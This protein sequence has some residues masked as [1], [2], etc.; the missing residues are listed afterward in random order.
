MYCP[1]CGN[2]LPDEAAFC[3]ACGK[4]VNREVS[5]ARRSKPLSSYDFV[6]A[7]LNIVLIL[8]VFMPVMSV[9]VYAYTKSYSLIDLASFVFGKTDILYNLSSLAFGSSSTLSGW[10][11]AL[12]WTSI[13]AILLIAFSNILSAVQ[14]VSSKKLHS[15]GFVCTVAGLL[16]VA[17]VI[18]VGASS[19]SLGGFFSI[20]P[21]L[22][23]LVVVGVILAVAV[24]FVL[25]W[26][27]KQ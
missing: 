21:W 26:A 16:C 24:G 1:G 12:G 8:S 7:L 20:S 5:F 14:D 6:F 15:G 25:G 19:G 3:K 27:D 11:T 13:I 22:W 10:L 9:D 4:R 18:W 23:I 17:V 2:E